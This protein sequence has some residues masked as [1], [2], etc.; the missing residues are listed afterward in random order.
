M[1][2]AQRLFCGTALGV[3]DTKK[4]K[5]EKKKKNT[6]SDEMDM[7][8]ENEINDRDNTVEDKSSYRNRVNSNGSNGSN[9]TNQ[10]DDLFINIKSI[11]RDYHYELLYNFLLM[12]KNDELQYQSYI[13]GINTIFTPLNAEIK[14][15]INNNLSC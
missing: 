6:T 1:L 15:W 2:I 4:D 7:N 12:V 3:T 11:Y 10:I 13:D 9:T 8:C 5:N 14:N